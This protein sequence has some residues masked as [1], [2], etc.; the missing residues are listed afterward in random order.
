MPTYNELVTRL[1][2]SAARGADPP[3]EVYLTS[4]PVGG[5]GEVEHIA[6]MTTDRREMEI[7]GLD[8]A[9][10]PRRALRGVGERKVSLTNYLNLGGPGKGTPRSLALWY[11]GSAS[12][13]AVDT[14]MEIDR[15][16]IVAAHDFRVHN[17][18]PASLR[19]AGHEQ[20]GLFWLD[21]GTVL[22]GKVYGLEQVLARAEEATLFLSVC[23]PRFYGNVRSRPWAS[24]LPYLALN[25]R[26]LVAKK[27]AGTQEELEVYLA[28]ETS[29]QPS[30]FVL[31]ELAT[32]D[33]LPEPVKRQL[34]S[35]ARPT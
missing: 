13:Q 5:S 26:Y 34:L 16:H 6:V 15:D 1:G 32:W 14:R 27:L 31:E 35:H 8:P 22:E 21:D 29:L 7:F 9:I 24:R 25:R 3:R 33:R 12:G 20:Y 30:G 10:D 18:A 19:V 17:P 23:N 2:E 11:F 4:A 28:L